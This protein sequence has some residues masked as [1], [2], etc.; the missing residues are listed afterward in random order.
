MGKISY[1][2]KKGKIT[3]ENKI[4]YPEAV[5][6]QIFKVQES[7]MLPGVLPITRKQKSKETKLT[8]TVQ[9]MQNLNEY[10]CGV[11]SKRKFLETIYQVVFLIKTYD[12]NM[13]N[14][15]N[16]DLQK[17]RVFINPETKELRCVYWPVVNNQNEV[18]AQAFF[19]Q[20]PIGITFDTYEDMSYLGEYSNFFNKLA[21]FSIKE[22]EKLV[23]KLQGKKDVSGRLAPS[24]S[25]NP[26][27]DLQSKKQD[28]NKSIEY[29]PFSVVNNLEKNDKGYTK[30]ISCGSQLQKG[31]KFCPNC[32]SQQ[33]KAVIINEPVMDPVQEPIK[34]QVQEV[35]VFAET[36][37]EDIF[38][39]PMSKNETEIQKKAVQEEVNLTQFVQSNNGGGTVVLSF[40]NNVQLVPKLISTRMRRS[41]IIDK[42][43]FKIGSNSSS[44]LL[45]NDNKYISRN[46]L[47]IITQND[48][49][50]AVDKGSTNK[51]Y[52][53]GK[54]LTP[55]VAFELF[56]NTEIKLAN[57]VFTFVIEA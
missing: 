45:I 51:S 43:V 48:R 18:P 1:E 27:P 31:A 34:Q 3:I 28:D 22:F 42:P 46:H 53:S 4:S 55:G 9:G 50:Y 38:P 16:L 13:I 17:D 29:D 52:V 8:C 7:N 20:L 5:N 10:F 15:S 14:P 23:L 41:I 44:D 56:H 37:Q 11:V 6:E 12:K 49:Y 47:E 54:E 33:S 39:Q 21:P 2:N 32:G 30:C 24:E 57:E 26:K 40:D 25:L 19:Q 36:M 35:E